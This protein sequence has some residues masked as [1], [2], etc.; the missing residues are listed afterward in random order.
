MTKIELLEILTG[1]L[2]KLRKLEKLAKRINEKHYRAAKYCKERI[3]QECE[4][5]LKEI[6]NEM[7]LLRKLRKGINWDKEPE[8]LSM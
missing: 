7:F 8:E 5:L 6:N 4:D 3:E 2:E 1:D